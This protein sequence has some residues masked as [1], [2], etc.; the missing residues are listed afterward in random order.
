MPT[1]KV[2]WFNAEKGFGFLSRDDGVRNG[3]ARN[4]SARSNGADD[5]VPRVQHVEPCR[6]QLL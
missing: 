6:E 2:K 3:S 4:V 5:D 1:G